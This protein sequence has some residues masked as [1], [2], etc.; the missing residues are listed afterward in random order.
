MLRRLADAAES[1]PSRVVDALAG[2]LTAYGE[3]LIVAGIRAEREAS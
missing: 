1:S 2:D 3:E